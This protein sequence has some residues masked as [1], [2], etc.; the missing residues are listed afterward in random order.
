[1]FYQK[2]NNNSKVEFLK[3]Q[4]RRSQARWTL[5]RLLEPTLRSRKSYLTAYIHL[6]ILSQKFLSRKF[7]RFMFLIPSFYKCK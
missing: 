7:F 1:L 5:A 6:M 4:E 2:N 3:E